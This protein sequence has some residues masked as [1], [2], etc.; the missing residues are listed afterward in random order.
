MDNINNNEICSKISIMNT[1]DSLYM[2]ISIQ[3]QELISNGELKSGD[4]LPP[5]LQLS[6]LLK[7]DVNT[8]KRAYTHLERNG[9]IFK[10]LRNRRYVI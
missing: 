9:Y 2:Q 10:G 3:F 7:V 4:I 8:V 5:M 6:K 1:S